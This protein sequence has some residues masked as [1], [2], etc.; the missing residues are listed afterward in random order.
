MMHKNGVWWFNLKLASVK[1]KI[2]VVK[3]ILHRKALVR[4]GL[5]IEKK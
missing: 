4:F 1:P 3:P 2:T 5:N